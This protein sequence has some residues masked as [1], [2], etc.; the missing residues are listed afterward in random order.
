MHDVLWLP[1]AKVVVEYGI[2]VFVAWFVFFAYAMFSTGS[3]FVPAWALFI[4]YHILNGSFLVP[5]N[6][7][8]CYVVVAAFVIR[9][10]PAALRK[11]RLPIGG[12]GR[13]NIKPRAGPII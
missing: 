12:A 5:P 13:F 3:P 7:F 11:I 1:L 4:Q 9:E 2:I 6:V 10:N 8:L